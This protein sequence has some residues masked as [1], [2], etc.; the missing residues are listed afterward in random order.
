MNKGGLEKWT[1]PFNDQWAYI[2]NSFIRNL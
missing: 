2:S 1:L